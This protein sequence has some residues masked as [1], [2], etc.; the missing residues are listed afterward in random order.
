MLLIERKKYGTVVREWEFFYTNDFVMDGI[1]RWLK[2]GETYSVYYDH[3]KNETYRDL[4]GYAITRVKNNTIYKQY[5]KVKPGTLREVY[6]KLQQ[7]SLT[8]K[9]LTNMN[10]IRY[11]VKYELD[12]YKNIFEVSKT[13]YSIAGDFYTKISFGWQLR[14]LKEEV[15]KTNRQTLENKDLV[16]PGIK[17]FLDPL[18]FYQEGVTP[19]QVKMKR[20]Q[21]L[22]K[23][24]G[25]KKFKGDG[26]SIKGDVEKKKIDVKKKGKITKIK[27]TP[28]VTQRTTP[29]T[30][31]T[32]Y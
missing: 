20:I 10:I 30:G 23:E 16:F 3:T 17:K 8:E 4:K 32:G 31:R 27:P 18:E 7:L 2:K 13:D 6:L 29:S 28:K 12:K 5:S 24:D 19:E 14:G 1:K 15:Q 9:E 21:K 25:G 22:I 11:F 26:G